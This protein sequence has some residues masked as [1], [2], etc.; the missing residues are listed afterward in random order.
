[1]T[2][3]IRLVNGGT[4]QVRTG[5]LQGVGP[6]GP[7]GPVGPPGPD[8]NQGPVGDPGVM[9]Q[10]LQYASKANVS[11]NTTVNPD[12]D[13][14]VAFATVAYDDMS[15]CTSS[16]NF[17]LSDQGDYQ[18]N[19]WV[20]F[21]KPASNGDGIRR[22]WFYSDTDGIVAQNSCLAV[23]DEATYLNLSFPYR[24]GGG[25]VINVYARSGDD[26][27]CAISAGSVAITRIGSGP[28]GPEGPPGPDGPT[29]PKGDT[30]DTGADGSAGSGYATYAD[31]LP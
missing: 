21:D 11:G 12:S 26:G 22:I 8:G 5:V 29:G 13:T 14:L 7:R 17:T 15:A 30:G 20:K 25:E 27:S 9:G 24:A 31:L 19:V 23:V 3:T 18:L 16:T 10:I 2:N 6:T 28:V 4:I 1:M